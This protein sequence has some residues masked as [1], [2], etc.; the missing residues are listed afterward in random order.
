MTGSMFRKVGTHLAIV[1]AIVVLVIAAVVALGTA[2]AVQQ[3]LAW[4]DQRLM[5]R[6]AE[7]AAVA[8]GADFPADAVKPI[9]HEVAAGATA[10]A[11]APPPTATPPG[12]VAVALTAA[13]QRATETA[14][15]DAAEATEEMGEA[16]SASERLEADL[17]TTE[18]AIEAEADATRRA[19][20]AVGIDLEDEDEDDDEAY[21]ER[22]AE[23]AVSG[24]DVL[25]YGI[26]LAGN[27]FI[28]E[29]GFALDGLP[30]KESCDTAM[31]GVV[32]H[33]VVDIDGDPMRIVSVPVFVDGRVV[34]V[35]QAA[36]SQAVH[37]E[38]VRAIALASAGGIL[39]AAIIAPMAG[40]AMAR[41]AMRPI[42]AAFS[43]Q[44]AFVADASHELRTPL[45]VLRANAE[46]TQRLAG[47]PPEEI[48]K[49]LAGMIEE[50]DVMNRLVDDL[51]FL[52]RSDDERGPAMDLVTLDLAPIIEVTVGA[53]RER[54]EQAGLTLAATAAGPLPVRGDAGRLRQTLGVLLDNAV[55]YTPAGGRIDVSAA[56]EG[57]QVVLQVRDTGIGIAPADQARVFDRFYRA[58]KARSR[59][60]GGTGLG[61]AIARAIVERHA[62]TIGV[63]SAPAAG[64]V[65][66]IRLPLDRPR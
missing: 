15:D 26:D 53:H 25:L 66:T 60:T 44:R 30:Q 5:E 29:R 45:T 31:A 46:L 16:D 56:I 40:I 55:L 51:L 28:N 4:E 2:V 18:S 21:A 39:I 43:R 32:D 37:A 34:G 61:L 38:E 24:G 52:A 36:K 27:V 3:A 9:D 50:I 48:R 20:E 33:R 12:E 22:F 35:V 14:A 64:S 62:G 49:E 10:S 8:W 7:A 58:D 65:F 13:A 59:R 19:A 17:E 47:A 57:A 6:R 11:P 41:R 23:Q 63:E 54:A 42:S 1:N